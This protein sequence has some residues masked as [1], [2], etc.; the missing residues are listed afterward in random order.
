MLKLSKTKKNLRAVLETIIVDEERLRCI[1]FWIQHFPAVVPSEIKMD[2]VAMLIEYLI[3]DDDDE[4]EI[5]LFG[6]K[7]QNMS[8]ALFEKRRRS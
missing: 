1:D 2:E 7:T 5:R 8:L 4:V 3:I 6:G